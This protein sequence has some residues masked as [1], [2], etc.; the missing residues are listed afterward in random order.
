MKKTTKELLNEL[1]EARD[2]KGLEDFL[3][4]NQSEMLDTT[5]QEYLEQCLKKY[6]LRKGD[7]IARGELSNY[8]YEIFR[9]EKETDRDRLIQ[10]CLGFPLEIEEVQKVL[11]LGKRQLLYARNERDAYVLFALKNGY[12]IHWLN[13]VLYNQ[14]LPLFE[15]F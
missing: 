3:V 6:R 10:I 4:K 2:N 7:V 13:D 1:N 15:K 14:E 8:A 5:L 9:G 12:D 11:Y